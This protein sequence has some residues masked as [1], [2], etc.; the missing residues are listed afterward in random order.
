MKKNILFLSILFASSFSY[1]QSINFS[2][3]EPQ[4]DLVEIYTG[5]SDSGDIDG[6]GD[7]DLIMTGITPGRET[8]L[9]LND[10]NG[11]FTELLNTSLPDA[12]NGITIFEDLDGDGDLDL[13]FSG[14][15]NGT[16]GFTNIYLNDGSGE[17]TLLPNPSIPQ[18]S[19]SGVDL[20]DVDGDG[21]IDILFSVK[22]PNNEYLADVLLNDGSAIFTPS[23]STVF[24]GV[25]F[26][27]IE[28]IDVEADG[29]QDVIISGEIEDGSASTLLY[30]NDGTGNFSLTPSNFLQMR[31][32]DI[33]VA[34]IDNDGDFDVLTS[35]ADPSFGVNTILYLNDG[36]GQFTQLASANLQ[37][38]FAGANAMVDFDNDGDKDIV[39][40]GSQDGGLPNIY[41]IIYENMSNNVFL[42]VDTI[43]GEYLATCVVDDFNGDALP[44]IIV[45]GFADRT[46]VYWNE[47]IPTSVDELEETILLNIFPNPSSGQLTISLEENIPDLDLSVYSIAGQ[48]VYE[49]ANISNV[50]HELE[51]ELPS[52][53]YAVL[54]KSGGAIV[55]RE[56]LSIK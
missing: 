56:L 30:L 3:A 22:D 14:A 23:G 7:N 12:N 53:M 44:D 46:T 21:D 42:P 35:G 15:A 8:A 16:L 49:E 19:D 6:D 43:G 28:F 5:S 4:P 26:G 31:A 54:L 52:G 1:A 13:Y 47:T 34:D 36:L 17:F 51:L 2:A 40:I 25:Q 27:S 38:T 10:G 37:H 55:S 32:E 48:L 39:I 50:K 41:N 20:E 9:Y 11:N 24:V 45:Q 29:D 18:H 33:D